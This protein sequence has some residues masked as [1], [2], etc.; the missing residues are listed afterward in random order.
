M[1]IVGLDELV[2]IHAQQFKR[3]QQVAAEDLVVDDSDDV[4]VIVL[5]SVLEVLQDPEL[6]AGLVLEPLFVANDFDGDHLLLF[7]VEALQRLA[8]AAAADFVEYLV[9]EGKVVFYDDLVVTAFVVVAEVVLV[10]SRALDFWR[11]QAEEV[12]VRIIA[13]FD[14]FVVG[15]SLA[16]VQLHRLPSAHRESRDFNRHADTAAWLLRIRADGFV[17]LEL[18]LR[19]RLGHR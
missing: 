4:V 1:K 8:E 17:Q 2:K 9:S 19:R 10:Q 5:V 14:L 7:V 15:E 12:H 16:A 6:H 11:L 13:H 3:N 18:T